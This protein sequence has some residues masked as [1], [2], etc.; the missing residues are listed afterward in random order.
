VRTVLEEVADAADVSR[1]DRCAQGHCFENRIGRTFVVGAHDE[2][3]QSVVQKHDVLYLSEQQAAFGQATLANQLA[4]LFA[5][6][7]ITGD[8]NL[9][10]WELACQVCEGPNQ[11]GIVLLL[12]QASDGA[13]HLVLLVQPESR[14][15]FFLP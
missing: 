8:Q 3:V 13:D 6:R 10:P 7:A 11:Q 9:E 15:S 2:E 14:T 1:D 12:L 4:Q 5:K